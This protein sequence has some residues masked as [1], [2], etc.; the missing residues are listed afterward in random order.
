[1]L[2]IEVELRAERIDFMRVLV[3]GDR[4]SDGVVD[5]IGIAAVSSEELSEQMGIG[6]V[7]D[8]AYHC[9]W[10]WIVLLSAQ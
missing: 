2:Q 4:Q 6:R 5:F 9:G 3:G 8:F 10:V 1:L 7:A